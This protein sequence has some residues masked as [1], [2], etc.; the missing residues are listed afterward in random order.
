MEL[1]NNQE[2]LAYKNFSRLPNEWPKQT[3]NTH[4]LH[5]LLSY[6]NAANQSPKALKIFTV[7]KF[8]EFSRTGAMNTDSLIYSQAAYHSPAVLFR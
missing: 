8:K 1:E 5:C 4:R 7:S 3:L 2:N 6:K